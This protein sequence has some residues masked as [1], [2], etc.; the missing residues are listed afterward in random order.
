MGKA[1]FE[2]EKDRYRRQRN[3]PVYG[4]ASR[5]N[6]I[7]PTWG[8]QRSRP[9]RSSSRYAG[10]EASIACPR[11]A[12]TRQRNLA[13]SRD[14]EGRGR[15]AVDARS[16]RELREIGQQV[17]QLS[18]RQTMRR[19]HWTVGK[20][21]HDLAAWPSLTVIRCAVGKVAGHARRVSN[22]SPVRSP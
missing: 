17:E 21:V 6:S 5:Q 13:P 3:D 2:R 20:N 10:P 19:P 9:N 22:R 12:S 15:P 14:H 18:G 8:F 16:R 1:S 7:R 11:L 4:L